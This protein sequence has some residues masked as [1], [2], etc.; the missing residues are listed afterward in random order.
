MDYKISMIIPIFNVESFLGNLID[1]LINQ[2]FGFE[3][4]ELILVDDCSTDNSRAI[5]E[6]Y[7]D[8][9]DNIKPIFLDEN[10]GA[11]SFPRNV[12]IEH[13][14]APYMQFV[15]ADDDV[16]RDYCRVLYD[17][18]TS[19][20]V[21]I[22]NCNHSSKLNNQLYISKDI[23]TI[24]YKAEF[25]NENDK[26]LLGYTA[27]GNIYTSSLIKENNIRFPST[28]FDDGVFSLTC[29]A[30]TSKPVIQIRDYPGYVYLIENEDSITHKASFKTISGFIEA[31]YICYDILKSFP[32]EIIYENLIN[33]VDMAIF[34]LVKLD[35]PKEGIKLL[36]D[37][38]NHV[39]EDIVLKS[40]PLD[41]LN[42]KIKNR[43]YSQA[44]FLVRLFGMFYNN[45][46]IRNSVFV[47]FSN[48][49]L[50]DD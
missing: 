48:L 41:I 35:N 5:I 13:A 38:E 36:A 33:F 39:S 16:D 26:M 32:K 7:A 43:N 6:S 18:I 45:K 12:G 21:D 8:K 19:N 30:K 3:N 17:L 27:W 14:T 37:F 11:A 24:N 40:K 23:E 29:L 44:L 4:I 25:V 10:S 31:Y 22:V 42:N 20:D 28:Q 47:K 2:T 1:S 34:I 46:K 15:D 50:K 49:R 9:Y